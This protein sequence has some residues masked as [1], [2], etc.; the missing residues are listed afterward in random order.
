MFEGGS[1]VYHDSIFLNGSTNDNMEHRPC[2]VLF[3][4]QRY[5]ENWVCTCPLSGQIKSFNK[6]PKKYC[7]IPEIA[8]KTFRLDFAKLDDVN[9]YRERETHHTGII[10]SDDVT[11]KIRTRIKQYDKETD[12]FRITKLYLEY[13]ELFEELEEKE[14]E[15]LKRKEKK[16]K[17]QKLKNKINY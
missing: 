9:F 15:K 10:I 1:I 13:L 2:V 16:L 4:I 3:N 7:F 12:L 6:N 5:N 14:K 8:Y 17:R 11:K